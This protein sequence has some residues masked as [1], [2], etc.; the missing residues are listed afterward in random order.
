[1][2]SRDLRVSITQAPTRLAR[3]H[4]EAHPAHPLKRHRL[5]ERERCID[6][7]PQRDNNCFATTQR[8]QK[9]GG[10]TGG[11]E[12]CNAEGRRDWTRGCYAA[13]SRYV[14]LYRNPIYF[15]IPAFL[16]HYVRNGAADGGSQALDTPGTGFSTA[17]RASRHSRNRNTLGCPAGSLRQCQRG[18]GQKGDG[19]LVT[20]WRRGYVQSTASRF[21]HFNCSDDGAFCLGCLLLAI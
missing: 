21:L 11:K 15:D 17:K 4:S 1:M 8:K 7:R 6:V 20:G 5:G 12:R 3:V 9:K 19:L 13:G 18:R 16:N 2:L 14:S 10:E